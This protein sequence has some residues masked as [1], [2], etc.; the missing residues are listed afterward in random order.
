[1]F[2]DAISDDFVKKYKTRTPPWGP[3]GFVVYKRTYA[4][5]IE[6]QGRTEEWWETV[7]RCCNGILAI[8]GKFTKEEIETLYDKVFNLKCCFSGRALWQLGTDTVKK[9]GGDS[10]VNCWAVPVD[11]PIKPFCFAFNELML[12]G[13]VGFNIQQEYVYDIPRVKHDVKIIRKDEKDVDFI[14]PD[15]REGWVDLLRKTLQ[16]FFITGK[17]FTYSTICVRSKGSL[18][19]S[20]GG[21]ASGPEELCGGIEHIAS[22][23]RARVG[24]KLR[25]IDCLD[26]MN[27]IGSVVVAGNV[28]RSAQLSLGD[29]NDFAY[30]DAK[31]WSKGSIPNWRAMSNNSLVC[32]KFEHLPP[33]FWESF[34]GNGEPLGLVNIKNCRAFGRLVDGRDYR[35]DKKIIGTNPCGEV[36][37]PPYSACN[38]FETFLPMIENEEELKVVTSLGVKVTKSISCM[39]FIHEETNQIVHEEYRL[40]N[41]VT[42]F[43]QAPQFH[44]E[45]LFDRVY[46]HL[47]KV[48]KEY[49][50]LLGVNRSIKLTTVKPSGTV[51]LMPGVTPGVHPA[52]AP[53]YLRRVRMASD[54]PLVEACRKNGYHVEPVQNFDG[55]VNLDTMV[56]SFPVKSP[57]GTICAKDVS[58]VKQMDYSKWLQTHWADNSVSVT[59][60]YKKE[61]LPA[62][63]KWL[64]DNYDKNVKT[65]SFCLHSEHGF[66][67][68]PYE[69]ITEDAYKQLKQKVKPITRLAHDEG[70]GLAESMECSSGVCPVGGRTAAR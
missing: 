62:I 6:D 25:P 38:L 56:V 30:L 31:N 21:T 66:R 45:K 32:N 54:D 59:I 13:G 55:T 43:L 11:D 70:M 29:F 63:K 17:N 50:A 3:I 52:F 20:F 48:D 64:E 26:I 4:R 68:P 61:E 15:N 18:I 49:S 1:M 42:G 69:E 39:N 58:A 22:V 10:L 14:V 5:K 24:E 35:P 57:A 36:P 65:I 37:L 44:D 23:L 33:K 12:G 19:Q 46:K 28:R 2:V 8:G 27:I 34:D 16:A 60:Y 41:S 40:G 51:S 53:F 47:E 67:Q 9:L 7:R